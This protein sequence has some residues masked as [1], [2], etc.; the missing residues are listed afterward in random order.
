MRVTRDMLHEELQPYY[1]RLM[2][3]T[4]V[5][6]TTIGGSL[7]DRLQ[8]FGRPT[9]IEGL[10]VSE[11]RVPSASGGPDV[12]VKI[13]RPDGEHGPLP[14]L[15]YLHGGAYRAGTPEAYAWLIKRFIDTRPC[16][17]AAPDYRLS[18]QAPYPAG[19]DDSYDTLL[20]MRDNAG[21][22]GID[23]DGLIVGGHS[24]GGGMTAAV[25]L[26]ARD[27]GDVHVAFQMPFYPMIDDRLLTTSSRFESPLY[28][29]TQN[30]QAWD[31]YLR[32]LHAAAEPVPAYAAPARATDH[33]GL[34]P[35]VTFVGGIDPF[36]DETAAYVEALRAA[37][38]PV[39]FRVF[40][41][42][43]HGFDVFAGTEVARAAARF[44]F[45]AF[46]D[47][48][49]TYLSAGRAGRGRPRAAPASAGG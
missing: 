21:D 43:F 22:L 34:P 24:A 3:F 6:R 20:W 39:T 32:G 11:V 17:V 48:Y 36:R 18:P 14:G 28:S 9:P 8:R 2:L 19:F 12:R 5:A 10:Q 38:V 46:A 42:C 47:L 15:L 40:D 33:A 16:V 45:G 7:L 23:P 13:Y 4:G 29:A 41:G 49:D 37:G 44:Q 25:T 26:K 31:L 1:T 27:T 35:T 30:A